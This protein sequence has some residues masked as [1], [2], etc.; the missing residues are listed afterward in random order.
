MVAADASQPSRLPWTWLKIGVADLRAPRQVSQ[1]A[2]MLH[3]CQ[4]PRRTTHTHTPTHKHT[5][6]GAV[7]SF[8]SPL[9]GT[10]SVPAALCPSHKDLL[11]INIAHSLHPCAQ[12]GY[13]SSTTSS[14]SG[15][16]LSALGFA[17]VNGAADDVTTATDHTGWLQSSHLPPFRITHHPSASHVF[18]CIYVN[19]YVAMPY[20]FSS[21]T[22]T[23]LPPAIVA[24]IVVG[25]VGGVAFVAMVLAIVVV[26]R[27]KASRAVIT[28]NEPLLLPDDLPSEE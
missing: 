4:P 15:G 1:H 18:R 20:F 5:D 27:G 12:S 23:H 14:K 26:R 16:F 21:L 7:P 10:H 8:F 28:L 2:R 22:L 13:S 9:L 25:S 19:N 24:A 11:Y 6:T 3:R 17:S